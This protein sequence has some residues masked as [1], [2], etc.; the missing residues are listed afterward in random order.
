MRTGV[1]II[2]REVNG[3]TSLTVF[4]AVCSLVLNA[5]HCSACLECCLI[6]VEDHIYTKNL[7]I[8]SQGVC[9]TFHLDIYLGPM[10]IPSSST[11][12]SLRLVS[13]DVGAL[14]RGTSTPTDGLGRTR[15][16]L[17]YSRDQDFQ[18]RRS[19][20]NFLPMYMNRVKHLAVVHLLLPN[21][22]ARPAIS[23]RWRGKEGVPLIGR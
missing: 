2:T 12:L 18:H 10:R 23:L 21:T 5:S 3:S 22:N 9:Q 4:Q 16:C 6:Q 17:T 1:V 20:G 13:G 19:V 14:L 7:P 15:H 8:K 11:R